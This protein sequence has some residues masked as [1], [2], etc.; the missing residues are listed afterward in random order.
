MHGM[1]PV[2]EGL[3]VGVAGARGT[4]PVLPLPEPEPG[5]TLHCAAKTQ[6]EQLQQL[7]TQPQQLMQ[8]TK[9]VNCAKQHNTSRVETNMAF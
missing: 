4:P 6:P 9:Q 2:G 8:L 5:R 1:V 7:Q 3:G